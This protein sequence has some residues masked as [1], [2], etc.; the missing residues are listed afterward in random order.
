MKPAS[1]TNASSTNAASRR[2]P[3]AQRTKSRKAGNRKGKGG[4][5]KK[6]GASKGQ[7]EV[8]SAVITE[9]WTQKKLNVIQ[10]EGGSE[11]ADE[12][13]QIIAQLQRLEH[14]KTQLAAADGPAGDDGVAVPAVGATTSSLSERP[15]APA[16]SAAA[17]AS[18][19]AAA[20]AEPI[21][22]GPHYSS[23][24]PAVT[25]ASHATEGAVGIG[26]GGKAARS[27]FESPFT[28][29]TDWSNLVDTEED[30]GDGSTEEVDTTAATLLDTTATLE[31]QHAGVGA[32]SADATSS[33]HTGAR[34]S[35]STSSKSTK[36]VVLQDVP[37]KP[38]RGFVPLRKEATATATATA[39]AGAVAGTGV[40]PTIPR[41][42]SNAERAEEFAR[43]NVLVLGDADEDDDLLLGDLSG[44][45]SS[46]GGGD[47]DDSGGDS[48]PQVMRTLGKTQAKNKTRRG[49]SKGGKGGRRKRQGPAS[50]TDL[51]L[52]SDLFDS[53][54]NLSVA[55]DDDDDDDDGSGGGNDEDVL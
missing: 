13:S 43:L 53:I 19:A 41:K 46:S 30:G 12:R 42:K 16:I 52:E 17:D 51:Q 33:I 28:A 11:A 49:K 44:E 27:P 45:G 35:K 31:D 2:V 4:G 55:D 7:P 1:S 14:M 24:V 34:E 39:G 10:S 47:D 5:G 40:T 15:N 3:A 37:H 54:R 36:G 20:A 8:D 23:P 22:P 18:S 29:I 48:D 6:M 9:E 26:G 38:S 50:L 32:V 21:P 25:A